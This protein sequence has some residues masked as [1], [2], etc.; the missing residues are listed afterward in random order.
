LEEKL[1]QEIKENDEL[2]K[3]LQKY[4]KVNQELVTKGTVNVVFAFSLFTECTCSRVP[5]ETNQADGT[6]ARR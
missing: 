3:T 4:E 6:K 1:E 5:R 2:D